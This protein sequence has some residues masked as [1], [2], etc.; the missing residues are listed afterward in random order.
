MIASVTVTWTVPSDGE[1][2][3]AMRAHGLRRIAQDCEV[4]PQ[5]ACN[6]AA[7]TTIPDWAMGRIC[8]AIGWS[9]PML[10]YRQLPPPGSA[11]PGLTVAEMDYTGGIIRKKAG[12]PRK[13]TPIVAVVAEAVAG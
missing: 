11:S 2:A 7:G 4:S 8:A 13:A 10:R 6:W 9:R 3:R 12:R 1:F 5:T